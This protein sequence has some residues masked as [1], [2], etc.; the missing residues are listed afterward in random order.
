MTKIIQ[1]IKTSFCFFLGHN[2]KSLLWLNKRNNRIS[3]IS[4][5][6]FF[7]GRCKKNMIAEVNNDLVLSIKYNENKK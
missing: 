5:I 7:C 2:M 4:T 6:R 3:D 1:I